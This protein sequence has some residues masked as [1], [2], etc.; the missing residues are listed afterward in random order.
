MKKPLLFALA[1]GASH[2]NVVH[3]EGSHFDLSHVL[4]GFA[5]PSSAST[6]A[7]CSVRSSGTTRD[8]LPYEAEVSI[9]ELRAVYPR[10]LS[11]VRAKTVAYALIEVG[12]TSH[13][14]GPNGSRW[15]N[16]RLDGYYR[17]ASPNKGLTEAQSALLLMPDPRDTPH[18]PLGDWSGVFA[19]AMSAKAGSGAYWGASA[20]ADAP[21][22]QRLQRKPFN[23]VPK[24]GDIAMW[25]DGSESDAQHANRTR[26]HHHSVVIA[27]DAKYAYT[28]DANSAC[29]RTLRM[30]RPLSR[31]Y[32]S[33]SAD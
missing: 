26:S 5:D 15:G 20:E 31:L 21:S 3:A 13:H 16:E 4:E 24:P 1:V 8:G 29:G 18:A 14:A 9:L 17:I 10:H 32:G 6:S 27:I 11:K 23:Q 25:L 19:T 12:A 2:V 28:I 33:Y 30:K 22:V 7:T